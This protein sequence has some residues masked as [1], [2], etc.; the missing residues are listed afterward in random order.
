VDTLSAAA[1]A[2]GEE[3]YSS[4]DALM[5]SPLAVA[6]YAAW[7]LSVVAEGIDVW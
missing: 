4:D 3:E 5:D 7:E 6:L 1:A 2:S